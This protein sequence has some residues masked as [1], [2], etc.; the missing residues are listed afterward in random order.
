MRIIGLRLIKIYIRRPL[1][2]KKCFFNKWK[3][4][5]PEDFYAT[6][7]PSSGI[8]CVALTPAAL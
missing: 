4:V 3:I 8:I 2:V 1:V 5:P 6:Q 7:K